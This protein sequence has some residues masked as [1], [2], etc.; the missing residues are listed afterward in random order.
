MVFV[1]CM[2]FVTSDGKHNIINFVLNNVDMADMRN[3]P[4]VIEKIITD[5]IYC[6]SSKNGTQFDVGNKEDLDIVLRRIATLDEEK[7]F[8]VM[9][10][11]YGTQLGDKL[12]SYMDEDKKI[13]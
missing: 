12:L 11:I 13:A 6:Y 1:T 3:E 8:Q 9:E 4:L 5:K 2:V 7:L 10:L